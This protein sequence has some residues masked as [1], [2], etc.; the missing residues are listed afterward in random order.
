MKYGIYKIFF[1]AIFVF[2]SYDQDTSGNHFEALNEQ[3]KE[4]ILMIRRFQDN[5]RVRCYPFFSEIL[6][7]L[8]SSFVLKA[9]RSSCV[10]AASSEL[11]GLELD[12]DPF[13][14]PATAVTDTSNWESMS[15]WE[16]LCVP[17]DL[18]EWVLR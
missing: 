15:N 6:H 9:K 2:P 3:T 13:T 11:S 10:D 17:E 5:L 14:T 18:V 7:L 16:L 12:F 1:K 4:Y 8:D